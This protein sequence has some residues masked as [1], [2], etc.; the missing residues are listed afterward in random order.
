MKVIVFGSSGFVGKNLV[1]HL[2]NK[3]SVQEVFVRNP[4]WEETIDQTS[5]VYINLIGKAHDHSNS[6]SEADYFFANVT[7]VKR[8]F[9][10]FI[11]SEASLFIH[12]SSIAAIE[13]FE[14][15]E[16]LSEKSECRPVSYYGKSKKVAEQWLINQN[17]PRGKKLIILRPPM[18]HGPG[19]KGNLGLLY[20]IISSGLPYPL[21]A[22][23]NKR[24]FLSIYN[25]NFYI[26]TII[27]DPIE[28]QSGIYNMSDD[29]PLST[30]QV[31]KIIKDELGTKNPEINLPKVLVKCTAILGDFL[32][33]PL[34]TKR[35][36]KLTSSLL[37][38]NQKIKNALQIDRLPVTAEQGLRKTIKSFQK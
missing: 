4:L 24:S 30:N 23:E 18:I 29:E 27:E 25:F 32:P 6:A 34:N 12:I 11:A 37:V 2:N 20:K 28:L 35:L 16:P 7:L 10:K 14:S 17:L 1:Q 38:S 26:S 21:A 5:D 19:D 9:K 15:T 36:Q 3:A 8:I 31:V 33:L 22:F 13:E